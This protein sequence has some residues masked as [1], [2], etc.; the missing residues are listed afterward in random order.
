M[1]RMRVLT[2]LIVLGITFVNAQFPVLANEDHGV[3]SGA[4]GPLFMSALMDLGDLR[5]ALP[6]FGLGADL[7]LA[8]RDLFL[9]HGGG[10]FGGADLL[11]MGYLWSGGR[12]SL[13]VAQS[14]L[15]DRASLSLSYS[16]LLL[17]QLVSEG[18]NMGFLLGA[19][20]GG[21][22]WGLRMSKS[23]PG[24]F[25]DLIL[26]P[27]ASLEL[28]RSFWF[29]L[30]YISAEFRLLSF[31]GLRVGAGFW[32][33]LSLD[34]WRLSDGQSA[35]GGPLKSAGFPVFQLMLIFGG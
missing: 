16:G 28:R 31:V 19:I 26:H 6:G 18:Q 2:G 30:P 3:F 9:L 32:G 34:D 17:E 1:S 15:F 33:A 35:A 24:G 22:E 12:W 20:V 8:G 23:P 11:R 21:G 14:P 25:E 27:A 4:G 5:K 10:G 7:S 29:A 13:S